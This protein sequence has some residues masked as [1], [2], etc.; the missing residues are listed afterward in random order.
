MLSLVMLFA[1]EAAPAQDGWRSLLQFFPIIVIGVVMF[2][3]MS[4]MKRQEARQR[5]ALLAALKKNDKVL[6]T[7]GIIG[8]VA[9]LK[10]GD[11]EVVLKVDES[12]NVRLRVVRSAIVRIFGPETAEKEKST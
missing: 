7:G 3:M 8:I 5:E 11:D 6:T 4:R 1:Q 10:D 9:S 2:W 12:S